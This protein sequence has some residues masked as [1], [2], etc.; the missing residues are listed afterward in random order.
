MVVVAPSE[1]L[2]VQINTENKS[3]KGDLLFSCKRIRRGRKAMGFFS[4]KEMR[5][6]ERTHELGFQK[7]RFDA[8]K[9][10]SSVL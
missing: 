5:G 10:K 4:N 6:R 7:S 9:K 2:K 1:I 8:R 3:S